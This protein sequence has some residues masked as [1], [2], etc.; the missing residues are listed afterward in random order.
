MSSE[1]RPAEAG[2]V[3]DA[4]VLD[5]L[6]PSLREWW[7]EEFG[8]YVDVNGG[9]FTPPQKQAVPLIHEGTNTL[10]ASPTGSGKTLAAFSSIINE[11]FLKS[12]K[13]ELDNTVYCLYISP[14]K[15]LANDIHRNLEVPLEGVYDVAE[16]NGYDLT[17]ID[18]AIRHGDTSSNERQKMLDDTPHILNTTP[19][20]LAILLNSP[21]FREKL[22]TVEYVVVDEIH[23]LADNKRGVHLSVALERL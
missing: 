6:E 19:E 20:T 3:D 12:K 4:H 15:S 1:S 16:E 23:S 11:L 7:R 13:E 2:D 10:I 18:H 21:K 8:D 17:E 22:R 9:Y 5:V 14:L